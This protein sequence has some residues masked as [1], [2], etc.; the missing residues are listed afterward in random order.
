M[1]TT[2]EM[3]DW[4]SRPVTPLRPFLPQIW[5]GFNEDLFLSI[6]A[7]FIAFELDFSISGII[8]IGL[9]SLFLF[10]I[11]NKDTRK[12]YS[13]S[14]TSS[15]SL[16]TNLINIDGQTSK[17][18]SPNLVD[19]TFVLPGVRIGM[20]EGGSPLGQHEPLDLWKWEDQALDGVRLCSSR[21]WLHIIT[22]SSNGER[23]E[24]WRTYE[25]IYELYLELQKRNS[26]II[27]MICSLRILLNEHS[28]TNNTTK[29]DTKNNIMKKLNSTSLSNISAKK[30]FETMFSPSFLASVK[31]EVLKWIYD[32]RSN[33]VLRNDG[34]VR[35][36]LRLPPLPLRSPNL[37]TPSSSSTSSTSASIPTPSKPS[38]KDTSVLSNSFSDPSKALSSSTTTTST[39]SSTSTTSSATSSTGSTKKSKG[40][41]TWEGNNISNFKFTDQNSKLASFG[42]CSR[43]KQNFSLRGRYYMNDK[44]K[45]EGR[46]ALG[47]LLRFDMII[48]PPGSAAPDR[49]DHIA[50]LPEVQDV[51]EVISSLDEKPFVFILNIQLPGDPPVNLVFYIAIP[52]MPEDSER[53]IRVAYD[54]FN[55]FVNIPLSGPPPKPSENAE[56][57]SAKSSWMKDIDW[58]EAGEYGFLPLDSFQN[59]RFKLIPQI[60]DAPWAVKM[61]VPTKPCIIGQKI[62]NRFFRGSNYFE[63]DMHV[64]SSKV[65]SNIISV[66]RTYCNIL[67]CNLGLVIQGECEEELPE[68]LFACPSLNKVELEY[69]H[70]PGQ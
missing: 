62:V 30:D 13:I 55:R 4:K 25:E 5:K 28:T 42:S 1:P 29:N 41:L 10:M 59:N 2:V 56:K 53:D 66:C 26:I 39:D 32:L 48:T 58:P 40:K 34:S 33:V 22:T 49:T 20:A 38:T 23:F 31:N 46:P 19:C 11:L 14:D 7:S 57:K 16:S 70:L 44:K 47:N 35:K 36:L 54:L 67:T 27:P 9:F 68:I 69:S 60:L 61:A 52:P 43:N 24:S 50:L 64:G 3:Y 51:I 12:A 65:A 37:L 45:G 21:L 63:A 18:S 8:W 17:Y 6:F 15:T